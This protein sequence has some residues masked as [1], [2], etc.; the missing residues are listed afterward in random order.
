VRATID[1]VVHTSEPANMKSELMRN[2]VLE[3]LSNEQMQT[4]RTNRLLVQRMNT[5]YHGIQGK[6]PMI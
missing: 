2:C 6:K 1:A 3:D 5:I 4:G